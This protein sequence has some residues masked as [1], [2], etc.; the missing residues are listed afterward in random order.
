MYMNYLSAQSVSVRISY[1]DTQQA[2][3]RDGQTAD[4]QEDTAGKTST[5]APK[6]G[7]FSDILS[8]M[9][10]DMSPIENIKAYVS[11]SV[12]RILDKIAAHASKALSDQAD[13]YSVSVTSVSI[14]IE[15]D[16]GETPED[17]KNQLDDMLSK[18]GYWGVDKTSQ[19]MFDFAHNMAGDDPDK[20]SAA[21]DAVLK[22][23]KQAEAMFGG[24]LP[25]ISYDTRDAAM[26]KF[27]DYIAKLNGAMQT[28][29]A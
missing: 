27:D 7:G 14:T 10:Q 8:I 2:K 25:Q 19:R 6:S 29:Y 22:G 23:F 4:K 16:S 26:K 20:L 3:V 11:D 17:I 15:A 24:K 28:T 1:A 5:D 12:A 13:T 9:S 18:D 21:K